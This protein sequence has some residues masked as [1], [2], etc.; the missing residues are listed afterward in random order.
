[1][2]QKMRTYT[3]DD[4]TTD[5]KYYSNYVK[6][7]G[8]D[9]TLFYGIGAT[10]KD[11]MRDPKLTE[12]GKKALFD[13]KEDA[14]KKIFDLIKNGGVTEKTMTQFRE[15]LNSKAPATKEK[16]EEIVP[17]K[18]EQKEKREAAVAPKVVERK[19]PAETKIEAPLEGIVAK[20]SAEMAK[21]GFV[22]VN[23]AKSITVGKDKTTLGEF[24]KT[25]NEKCAKEASAEISKEVAAKPENYK[26]ES[27][28]MGFFQRV[29]TFLFGWAGYMPTDSNK[30]N[31]ATAQKTAEKISAYYNGE[32][33]TAILRANK[34]VFNKSDS[35]L[36]EKPA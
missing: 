5:A 26:L 28:D 31:K 1:M 2:V 20:T 6:N 36:Y 11:L 17:V 21:A 23:N 4:L 15:Y 18:I 22:G 13:N 8:A 9:K 12:G 27:K 3:K 14:S 35:V 24:M 30:I 16:K 32:E 29:G 25:I 33:F 7:M 19:K 10:K 34:M